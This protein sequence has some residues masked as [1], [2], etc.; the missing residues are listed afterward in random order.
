LSTA[1][2]ESLACQVA[3][4]NFTEAEWKHFFGD[5]EFRITCPNATSK[6]A[7][8]RAL[9][10]DRTGAEQLF[11][12]ALPAAL[13]MK[14]PEIDN[15]V[16]WLGSIHGFAK[17]VQPACE[18][19]VALAP[20]ASKGFYIDS[21]GLARARTGDKAGAIEDFAAAMESLK[22]MPGDDPLL[23]KRLKRREEWIAA[24][25]DNRDPFDEKLLKALRTE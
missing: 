10:G 12:E 4:R 18:Q 6:K 1:T 19:A 25:K 7:D 21:R 17:M 13:K 9:A 20:E 14:D 3:G 2:W 16:C 23:L 15:E 24:L 8:E 11:A 22:V 5:R